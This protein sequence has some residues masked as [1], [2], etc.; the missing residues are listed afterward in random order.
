[1]RI[2][3]STF[4][5]LF[6]FLASSQKEFNIVSSASIIMDMAQHIA[7]DKQKIQL[8]V[9][10]GGDPHL[11][12]PTPRDARMVAA[13]DLVMINGMT[14]EGWITELIDNSGTK[15]KVVTMTEGV[16]AI[17]S[18][19]YENSSDPHAWMDVSNGLV[20][21]KNIWQSL[22]DLDPANKDYYTANYESYKK[23]IEELDTYIQEE[24]RKIPL[25]Q[26]VLI[27]SHDAFAYYGKRYGIRVEAL[28]GISTEAQAGTNDMTRV[29]KVIRE[30]KVP[31]IFVE[32]TINPKLI[33]QIAKDN[34]VVIGGEL[35]ADSIGDEESEGHGYTE[36]L[37]HNTDTIVKAL[38][39]KG[40]KA[41][42]S[43]KHSDSNTS[44]L[45]L[46]LLAGLLLIGGLL[47]VA[48]KLKN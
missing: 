14:F 31:A 30:N 42:A 27:T 35:F 28:M 7:G 25:D 9:P 37:R 13:A 12:R 24:I 6:T 16:N 5:L 23:E 4:F 45:W 48:A 34:D 3:L 15:A 17:S 38:L 8:I 39:N 32:S 2:I 11:H 19:E 21:I 33:N 36:M 41:V 10:I 43:Q 46:Y 44:S 1:M 18:T 40:G 20:Y 22:V 26:R 47:L 29:V